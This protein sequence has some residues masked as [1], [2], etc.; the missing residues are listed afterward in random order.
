MRLTND[1][2][3]GRYID[4]SFLCA[5]GTYRLTFIYATAASAGIATLSIDGANLSP[6]IDTYASPGSNNNAT[7]IADIPLLAGNHTLRLTAS[8][9]HAS[10]V[11]Y[12]IYWQHICL[13]RTG[14]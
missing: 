3:V 14:A 13:L 7:Q 6:T 9:K 10:S 4:Y 8:G 5:S 2:V 12:A 11:G 1:S